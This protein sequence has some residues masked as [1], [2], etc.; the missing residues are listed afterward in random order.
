M[1]NGHRA[2]IGI[3]KIKRMSAS[4]MTGYNLDLLEIVVVVVVVSRVLLHY[5]AQS[6]EIDRITR[7][8]CV[9]MIVL[10]SHHTHCCLHR[11]DAKVV[12]PYRIS[13]IERTIGVSP[14]VGGLRG[15]A[16]SEGRP[17]GVS[18]FLGNVVARGEKSPSCGVGGLSTKR[19]PG[20]SGCSWRGL[21]IIVSARGDKRASSSMGNEPGKCIRDGESTNLSAF[22]TGAMSWKLGKDMVWKPNDPWLLNPGVG[23]G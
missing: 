23:G 5:V 8:M 15:S 7:G 21:L 1:N 18:G 17:K 20:T 19:K 11:K 9:F 13:S 16:I 3:F 2:Q 12:L 22:G 4:I 10:L 14:L 6:I